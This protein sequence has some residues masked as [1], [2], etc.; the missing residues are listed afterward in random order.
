MNNHIKVALLLK[1]RK[2]VDW[3]SMCYRTYKDGIRTLSDVDWSDFQKLADK[4]DQT[5]N[6]LTISEIKQIE[7]MA[8]VDM[9]GPKHECVDFPSCRYMINVEIK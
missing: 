9:Y 5:F 6:G 3:M 8:D 1:L 7:H 2:S 4:L